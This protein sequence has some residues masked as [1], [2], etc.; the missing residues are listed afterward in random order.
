MY[1]DMQSVFCLVIY[2]YQKII[3]RFAKQITTALL[4]GQRNL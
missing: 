3:D 4:E 1:L 2:V